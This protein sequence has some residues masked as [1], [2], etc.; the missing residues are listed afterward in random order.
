MKHLEL[1]LFLIKSFGEE[2][3]EVLQNHLHSDYFYNL[4]GKLKA[5]QAKYTIY[6]DSED[7]FRAFRITPFSSLKGVILGQDF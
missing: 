3:Y 6:P 1:R 7:I 4:G 2:W 5:E